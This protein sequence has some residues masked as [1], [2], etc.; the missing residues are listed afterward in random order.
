MA[1]YLEQLRHGCSL[2]ALQSVLAINRTT[3]V[4]HAGQGCV[5]KLAAAIG[6]ANGFH[7][8]GY[9]GGTQIPCTN[10]GESEVVFGG[11][12]RLRDN[13][14]YSLK[15]IDA[16]LFIV[17]T[18]CVPEIVGDDGE[19]VVKDF[20]LEGKPV[21]YAE[22]GGFNG[23]N[24]IGHEIVVDA[25]IDQYM[26]PLTAVKSGVVNIWSVVPFQDPF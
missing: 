6:S 18:G 26:E 2:G 11:E 8:A 24:Y 25:L 17:L 21:I 16:D 12:E 7:G 22:T 10:L 1:Q 5:A 15:V 20:Q 14:E 4:V 19:R 23:T 9:L 13:I 3:P